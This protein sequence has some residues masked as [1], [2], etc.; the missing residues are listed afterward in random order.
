MLSLFSIADQSD[1]WQAQADH[2]SK[3]VVGATILVA[4][5]VALEGVEFLHDVLA[6]M[7]RRWAKRKERAALREIAEFAPVREMPV[8]HRRVRSDAQPI[9][10]TVVGHIGLLL[11]VV[12]V[13]GEWKYGAKFEDAQRHLVRAARDA[14]NDAVA[15]AKAA[16]QEADA[17]QLEADAI[18]KRL[19]AASTRMG[20]LE[21]DILA[22]GPRWRL[23]KR[24]EGEFIKSLTPFHGQRLTVVIC[25]NENTEQWQFEQTLIDLLREAKWDSP[26]YMNWS[27]C[28]NML[29]AGTLMYFVAT[30]DDSTEWAG[31]PPQDWF[32]GSCGRFNISHDAFSTLCDVLYRLRIFTSAFREKPVPEAVGI[33]NA[34]AFFGFNIPDGPA[35]LAYQNPG[36]IF[37]LIG[38]STP[39]FA[40]DS[41]RSHKGA[42]PK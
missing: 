22:E 37:I 19:E 36:T 14:A 18:D 30:T 7:K 6:W 32:K 20:A 4:I 40:D 11:V 16:H 8:K 12:G 15:S 38:P 26:G 33:K 28:P 5:G 35:E 25:A 34:R 17:V 10:V 21:E 23:L 24:G 41:K 13:I 42:K 27:G 9:W 2:F 31:L 39:M 3:L 29:G 1:V